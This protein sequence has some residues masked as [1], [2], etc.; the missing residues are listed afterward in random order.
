MH[1]VEQQRKQ[2]SP[3]A[4]VPLTLVVDEF[5]AAGTFCTFPS[6]T[7][8]VSL[9]LSLLVAIMGRTG[10]EDAAALASTAEALGWNLLLVP[11]VLPLQL[12]KCLVR[13]DL[14]GVGVTAALLAP[15]PPHGFKGGGANSGVF[16]DADEGSFP[17]IGANFGGLRLMSEL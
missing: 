16:P 11:G 15:T 6:K 8:L 5:P 7:P 13:E 3:F 17:S 14:L 4:I 10:D 1:S 2:F 9:P 12:R